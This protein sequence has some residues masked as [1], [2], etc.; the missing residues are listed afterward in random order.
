MR[1]RVLGF[2]AWGLGL[3][4]LGMRAWGLEFLPNMKFAHRVLLFCLQDTGNA[5]CQRGRGSEYYG[6]RLPEFRG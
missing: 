1:F 4:S 5:H 2:R 6:R 3:W